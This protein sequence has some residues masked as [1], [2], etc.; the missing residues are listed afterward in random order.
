MEPTTSWTRV[1]YLITRPRCLAS[2]LDFHDFRDRR[3]KQDPGRHLDVGR[4]EP[5]Q[6]E[7]WLGPDRSLSPLGKVGG[8][9]LLWQKQTETLGLRRE[10]VKR[11]F[12]RGFLFFVPWLGFRVTSTR[13]DR[14]D[15][16]GPFNT[17]SI[18]NMLATKWTPFKILEE[19]PSWT[20]YPFANCVYLYPALYNLR[21]FWVVAQIK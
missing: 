1:F 10:W 21:S 9:M 6:R 2:V 18:K 14:R 13:N 7:R 17:G 20:L 16:L 15:K 3:W 8:C 5:S 19:K 11:G 12:L 4:S